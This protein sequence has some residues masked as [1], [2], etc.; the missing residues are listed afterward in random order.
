MKFFLRVWLGLASLGVR[1]IPKVKGIFYYL[2]GHL[3]NKTGVVKLRTLDGNKLCIDLADKIIS[4]KLLQYGFWEEGLTTLVKKLIKP[5]M[6]VLDVG[7]HVGYYSTLF[8][9]LTGPK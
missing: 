3:K 7:A 8:S 2:Y 9:K 6:V 5:N 1:R 4:T